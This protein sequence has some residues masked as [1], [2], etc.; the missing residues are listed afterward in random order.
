MH[1]IPVPHVLDPDRI[2]RHDEEN[3]TAEDHRSRAML[4][5][6][7]LHETSEYGQQL[8]HNLEALRH[9]LVESLPADPRSP[10]PHPFLCASPT[11]PDDD[12]G[13]ERWVAAYASV[14]S[15]LCGPQ[16]DS[17]QGLKDARHAASERRTG[18]N[19]VLFAPPGGPEQLRE[20]QPAAEPAAGPSGADAAPP[21]RRDAVRTAAAV[22]VGLLALRGLRPRRRPGPVLSA[23]R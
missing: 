11:G 19:V 3:V 9:Y 15:V 20:P 7:A 12:A 17:G 14:N 23:P 16:G 6:K 13:W 4:L 21:V 22:V 2:L 8:W 18:A 1:P 10:G 5:E